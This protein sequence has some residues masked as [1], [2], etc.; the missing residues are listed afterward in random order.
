MIRRGIM[1]GSHKTSVDIV[2]LVD[3]VTA[4]REK[5]AQLCQQLGITVEAASPFASQ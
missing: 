3:G 5:L 4:A 1:L 2:Q